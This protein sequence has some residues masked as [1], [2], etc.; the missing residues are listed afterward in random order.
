MGAASRPWPNKGGLTRPLR[1]LKDY[2]PVVQAMLTIL[3]MIC[4]KTN[5][6]NC[7]F[8]YDRPI[9]TSK[10]TSTGSWVKDVFQGRPVPPE[11]GN[12][13]GWFKSDNEPSHRKPM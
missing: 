3:G 9:A 1:R 7:G 4:H 11:I 12:Y 2:R 10:Q 5:T 6:S 13:D 8:D